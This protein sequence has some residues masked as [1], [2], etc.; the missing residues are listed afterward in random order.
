M[1]LDALNRHRR[2][3]QQKI[4]VEASRVPAL[5]AADGSRASYRFLE[6][7]TAQIRNPNTRR[8]Y[9]RAAKEFFDYHILVGR[10]MRITFDTNTFDKAS[11]P[12][13]YPQNPELQEMI[14]VHEALKRGDIQGFLS[15]TALTLEGITNDQRATVF[16][17]TQTRSSLTQ[18]A[19]DTFTI[20]ITPEQVDRAPLHPKQ[21]ERFIEAFSLGIRLL[22]APRIG[23]PRAEEQFYAVEDAAMLGER[24]NRFFKL[25]REI[26]ARGLG[27]SRAQGIA[28]RFAGR[29][30]A[31]GPWF[32]AL[33]AASDIHETREVARAVAE[34]ADGDS[35]AAH[36][37][38]G[39]NIFCTL[40]GGKAETRRGEPAVLDVSNRAWLTEE[41]GIQF[42]TLGELAQW[43]QK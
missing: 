12:T 40:D 11:R 35:V 19:E 1:L 23:M 27:S 37:A 43:L 22:G 18:T 34:W 6:F 25:V 8:A 33:G 38:Y 36:Y 15:D 5:V 31:Q 7:F 39:N 13:I 26:E 14:V 4:T 2:K 16:G 3:G 42:S 30:S 9:A 21:G 17:S 41:F 10:L 32:R 20:T 29:E 24:L 28:A